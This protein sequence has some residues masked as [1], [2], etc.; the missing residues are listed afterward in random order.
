MLGETVGIDIDLEEREPPVES[1]S[2]DLF[3]TEEGTGRKIII[4]NQLKN[5]NHA[6]FLEELLCVIVKLCKIITFCSNLP[7]V[8]H[9]AD[10]MWII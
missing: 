4:A 5:T 6:E 7:N 9:F 1:F 10:F 8:P 3:A 2:V